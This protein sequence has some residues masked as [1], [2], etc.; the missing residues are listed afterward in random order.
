MDSIYE[1]TLLFDFYGELL[2]DHQKE[3]CRLYILEDCSLSEIAEILNVTR[4][5]VHDSL[6]RAMSALRDYENTL[7]LVERFQN[8][9]RVACQ[10]RRLAEA[11]MSA[12][13][14][15]ERSARFKQII[16]LAEA[17]EKA[18]EARA[19][20]PA[21][22]PAAFLEKKA[23]GPSASAQPRRLLNSGE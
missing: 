10:I 23:D 8:T 20:A 6:K 11:G 12:E 7:H 5:S 16:M 17:I 13:N 9:K 22:P 3:V 15:A 21:V 14:S 18:D 1:T 19:P 2:T 4:Q